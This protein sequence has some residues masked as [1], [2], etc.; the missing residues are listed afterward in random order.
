MT[1]TFTGWI[2]PRGEGWQI[3]CRA[4]SEREAWRLL[5]PIRTPSDCEKYVTASGRHPEHRKRPR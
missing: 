2:R 5:I 3:A 1:T 4:A